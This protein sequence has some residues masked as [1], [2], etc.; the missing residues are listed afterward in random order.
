MRPFRALVTCFL[1]A[2][3]GGCLAEDP[4]SFRLSDGLLPGQWT[5][6]EVPPDPPWIHFLP[7]GTFTSQSSGV[8]GALTPNFHGH[9]WQAGEVIA[10]RGTGLINT[11][12]GSGEVEG[13]RVHFATYNI[14][15]DPLVM[16]MRAID[17]AYVAELVGI[18]DIND[19]TGSEV[20]SALRRLDGLP[21]PES[22]LGFI[23]E[24]LK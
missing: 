8:P 4:S 19:L 21:I 10:F 2:L 15:E 1:L 24:Y 6:V 9:Y 18:E 3:I 14:V 5:Q 16:T 12:G 20:E 11:V 23:F 17:R 22:A 7:D 13:V